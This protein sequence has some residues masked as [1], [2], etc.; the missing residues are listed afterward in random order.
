M[1]KFTLGLIIGLLLGSAAMGIAAMA[2][3]R[4]AREY[5]KF[6]ETASGNTSILVTVV[7]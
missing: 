4:N 2:N 3:S 7:Q 5:D 6:S 1:K